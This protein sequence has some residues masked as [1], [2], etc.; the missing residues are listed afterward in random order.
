MFEL[1]DH[2]KPVRE[3]LGVWVGDLVL[4]PLGEA[5]ST[6]ES[7]TRTAAWHSAPRIS[8]PGPIPGPAGL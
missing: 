4:T 3:R 2:V 7:A 8:R 6:L 5:L 1:I